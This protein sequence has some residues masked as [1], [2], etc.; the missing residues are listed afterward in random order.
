KAKLDYKEG[1]CKAT[2]EEDAEDEM[3]KGFLLNLRH[4]KELKIGKRC[5]QVQQFVS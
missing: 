3:L 4:V 2:D 1:Y 5:L